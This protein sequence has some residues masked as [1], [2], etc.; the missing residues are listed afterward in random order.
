MTFP[1]WT[2]VLQYTF[3]RGYIR[4]PLLLAIPIVF[5]KYVL[6]QFEPAYQRWNHGH[7]QVD[8]WNRLKAKV[9][10]EEAAEE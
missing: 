3:N 5:N 6:Y 8:I 4:I 1:I 7:N 10:A 9:E 2:T